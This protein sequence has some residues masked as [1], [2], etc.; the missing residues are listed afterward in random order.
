[1][2]YHSSSEAQTT[3]QIETET[4]TTDNHLPTMDEFTTRGGTSDSCSTGSGAT[5]CTGG[6]SSGGGFYTST[7]DLE[8]QMTI[9]EINAGFDLDY[10]IDVMSHS[11]N[12]VLASCVNGNLLQSSDCRDV[13]N[14]T[15]TLFDS[16]NVL[17]HKF[18][19]SVELDYTGTRSFSFNQTIPE[20]N[21]TS[22]TGEFELFGIDAG[23]PRGFFGPAFANPTLTTTFELVTLLETEVIDILNTTDILDVNTPE[24]VEVA[25]IEVEIETP[26]G[27]QM[28]SLE[29]E[30][31]TEM[32]MEIE[33]LELPSIDTQSAPEV[34]VEVSEV[35][36][37]LETE[38]SNAEPAVEEPVES[39]PEGGDEQS[40]ETE[41]ESEPETETA[42]AE[43]ESEAEAEPEETNEPET[44]TAEA[45]PETQTAENNQ[46]ENE[47]STDKPKVEKKDS[48]KQKAARKIV[49]KMGDKG[50]YDSTN[51]LKTLVIMNVLADTKNFLVQPTIPQPTGFFTDQKVPDAQ[52]PENN[53][54]AW[55]LMGGSNQLHD[56][57][58]G[59]QYK[60]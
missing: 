3:Q 46:E 36:A 30:V 52:L 47:E 54:A 27:Q 6:T 8:E 43:P 5:N 25:T 9:D 15:V 56:R 39:A 49:K 58:T 41:P 31:N 23:F 34:E 10:G 13:F 19:H 7:F 44:E 50:R 12:S 37:E 40:S 51:Q 4:V 24:D 22:L 29:L 17:A 33:P 45:E 59:L 32:S 48:A 38:M 1:M 16:G 21:F 26:D 28:A 35:S 18:E 55:M 53:A 60:E 14:L 42:E 2:G 57:L 11:S 20:N